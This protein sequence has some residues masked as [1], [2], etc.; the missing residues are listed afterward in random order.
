ML[1]AFKCWLNYNLEV[2]YLKKFLKSKG[3]FIDIP[4]ID[5]KHLPITHS[6]IDQGRVHSF[7]SLDTDTSTVSSN[8]KDE[9]SRHF[10][11]SSLNYQT[12]INISNANFNSIFDGNP[13]VQ[14]QRKYN[15]YARRNRKVKSYLRNQAMKTDYDK[16][17]S[18]LVVPIPSQTPKEER[19]LQKVEKI[20]KETNTSVK[21]V[22]SQATSL[23]NFQPKHEITL[24]RSNSM[25]RRES[26]L[27]EIEQQ[28]TMLFKDAVGR[29]RERKIPTVEVHKMPKIYINERSTANEV[30]K[31]LISKGFS[32]R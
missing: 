1:N 9:L 21:E 3:V 28:K 17:R 11:E 24:S 18:S 6:S 7:A 26:E 13:A 5:P 31:F 25:K 27:N 19:P 12:N 16:K 15:K 32:E 23:T 29:M 2:S 8:V 22:K 14:A 10:R 4:D 30:K 20:A